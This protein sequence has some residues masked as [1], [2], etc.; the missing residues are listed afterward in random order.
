MDA[1]AIIG[2]LIE[3]VEEWHFDDSSGRAKCDCWTCGASFPASSQS[4]T[5]KPNCKLE[6]LLIEARK[7]L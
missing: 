2:G 7:L 1:K 3:H 6:E 4:K 5:H